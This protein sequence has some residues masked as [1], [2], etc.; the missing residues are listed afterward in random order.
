MVE[1]ST[2]HIAQP[3]HLVQVKEDNLDEVLIMRCASFVIRKQVQAYLRKLSSQLWKLDR[4][5]STTT[6]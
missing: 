3:K 2:V 6:T 5:L 4:S 1:I